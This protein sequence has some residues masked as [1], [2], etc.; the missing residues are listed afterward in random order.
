MKQ[1]LRLSIAAAVFAAQ[2]VVATSAIAQSAAPPAN[3][4]QPQHKPAR[5]ALAKAHHAAAQDRRDRI[6]KTKAHRAEA[7]ASA[8]H[9]IRRDHRA[10]QR[11]SNQ[12]DRVQDRVQARR[13]NH[14]SNAAARDQSDHRLA[15]MKTLRQEIRVRMAELKELEQAMRSNRADRLD[16]RQSRANDPLAPSA[17]PRGDRAKRAADRLKDRVP[18]KAHRLG[19][20][21]NAIHVKKHRQNTAPSKGG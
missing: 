9:E 10:I 17:H 21:E 12:V 7:R 2:T 18:K 8:R 5:P 1:Q 3:A 4:N 13:D 15:R 6:T 14:K 16:Q 19:R 20:A 11:A